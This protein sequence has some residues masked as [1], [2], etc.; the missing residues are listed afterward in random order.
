VRGIAA[1]CEAFGTPVVSGNVSLYN[2]TA[3]RAVWPTPVVGMLG[4]LEDV[5]KHLRAGFDRSGAEVWLLGGELR[6]PAWTLG[7]SQY[8]ESEHGRVA[9]LPR[10][11]LEHERRLHE[12]VLRAHAEGLLLSAHDCSD[13]GLAVTV[14]ES[15]ML[16]AQG[17]TG[18]VEF[19]GRL[20]AALFGEA[21]GRVVVSLVPDVFR[22]AGAGARLRD[23]AREIGVPAVRLGRTTPGDGFRLGPI[24]TTVTALRE[25]WGE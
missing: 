18:Q 20:D 7:G 6:Q 2:E 9:G 15:A 24:E 19:E 17:F 21:Q 11:D 8:L 14:A 12:L 25:A 3:G 5:S 22:Q 1:A 16:G 13:G 4:L 10:V 23:L